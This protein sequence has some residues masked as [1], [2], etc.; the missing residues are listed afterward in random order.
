MNKNL[1]TKLIFITLIII[2]LIIISNE[3]MLICENLAESVGIE[4]ANASTIN[5]STQDVNNDA[6]P[7]VFPDEFLQSRWI[8]LPALVIIETVES[9][10]DESTTISFYPDKLVLPI[11]LWVI[12]ANEIWSLVLVMP[13]WLVGTEDGEVSVTV[14]TWG[15]TLVVTIMIKILPFPF[16]EQRKLK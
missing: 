6:P 15:G 3:N 9:Y 7:F 16:D 10:F 8:P 1:L 11:T 5:L 13:S 14:T 12:D 4:V 2:P